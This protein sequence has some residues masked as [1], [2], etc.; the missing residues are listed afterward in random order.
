MWGVTKC[1]WTDL[2]VLVRS[3]ELFVGKLNVEEGKRVLSFLFDNRPMRSSDIYLLDSRN[4][5]CRRP[6]LDLSK[7]DLYGDL[8]WLRD[9]DYVIRGYRACLSFFNVLAR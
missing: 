1:L 3:I 7:D 2:I 5:E 8:S 9:N 6:S 4:V